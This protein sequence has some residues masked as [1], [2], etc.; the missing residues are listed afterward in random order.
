MCFVVFIHA[1]NYTI[2]GYISDK[3][4]GEKLLNASIYDVKLLKGTVSNNYGFYSLSLPAGSHTIAVSFVGYT[5]V[6]KQFTL[7]ANQTWD[8]ELNSAIEL[9]EVVV[10][11][12]KIGSP[13]ESSRMSVTEISMESIKI[14]PVLLGESDLIKIAQLQPGV[15]G[16][17]EGS[18]GFFVRGGGAD[19]NLILL[20]GVPIY[21]IN[22]LFGFFSIFNADAINSVTLVKGGFPARYGGRLSSV[23][24]IR[25][26]EGNNKKF[27]GNASIGLISAKFMLEGPILDEQTSFIISGR[28][29]YID[30]I[31]RP[32]WA[33]AEN[34]KVGNIPGYYFY[35]LNFKINHKINNRHRLYLSLYNGSDNAYFS[36]TEKE[37][38]YSYKEFNTIVWGNLIGALRWNYA[39]SEK[40]FANLNLTYSDY[41][42]RTELGH[43]IIDLALDNKEG[44][45]QKYNSGIKDLS[46]KLDFDFIPNS[47]NYIRFGGLFTKHRFTPGV[48]VYKIETSFDPEAEIDSVYGDK[49]I[50]ANE[51]SAYIEDDVN[52]GS[53]LKTNMGFH[54]SVFEVNGRN[55]FSYEPRFSLRYSVT[56]NW[57]FKASYAKMNQN[58]HLLTSNNVGLP[59]DLWVPATD[60]IL[61][62]K[63][64]QYAFGSSFN[65][66]KLNFSIEAYYKE[67]DNIIEYKEGASYLDHKTKWEDKVTK[68]IGWAYGLEFLV[69]KK[70][71]K[72]TGW[73]GYT[74][75][76]AW[77][78]SPEINEGIKFPYR[79]DR[80]HDLSVTTAYKFNE[81]YDIGVSWIFGTGYATTLAT[82]KYLNPN[83]L[84]RQGFQ[85]EHYA[86]EVVEH[87]NNYRMPLYHRLD[88]NFNYKKKRK[89]GLH[90]FSFGAYNAYNR[91]NPFFIRVGSIS[92]SSASSLVGYSLSPLIP[93]VSYTL[94]F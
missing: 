46:S 12:S 67:M 43:E 47:A 13:V 62:Q 33:I 74:L 32:I 49:P 88:F 65:V 9:G 25:M 39:I 8:I 11:G 26:K 28:R 41:N 36:L 54:F 66:K 5:D 60:R 94:N 73:L 19:Q 16:G 91:P 21:N 78:Q 23:L 6:I 37:T 45:Y 50:F 44:L 20:D 15:Q 86:I 52:L 61:P 64:V 68:G 10:S 59:I 40:L 35:D 75:A 84:Y 87:R 4:T 89:F 34:T 83:G 77:R 53:R 18:S 38:D 93:N 70:V 90:T 22:H 3:S 56:E 30:A 92:T 27:S 57:S 79:Y 80:R 48:H 51:Y 85:K 7:T 1:Q 2:S 76:W 72:F 24:D 69:E 55:Y 29:T 17:T 71:G 31:I 14:L 82:E 81:E 58:I 63:S 42:F